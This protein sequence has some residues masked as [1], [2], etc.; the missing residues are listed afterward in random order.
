M[1]K[2]K[3]TFTV[4]EYVSQEDIDSVLNAAFEE[5]AEAQ[6]ELEL[7]DTDLVA[8]AVDDFELDDD[9][10]GLI[11][12]EDIEALLKGAANF[13]RPAPP[14][15]P[16]GAKAGK[17][18]SFEEEGSIVSQWDIDAL[19]SGE[20]TGASA[21]PA[22]AKK[23]PPEE[24]EDVAG[25]L[26]SQSDI[27]A[28]LNADMNAEAA[29]VTEAAP[30]TSTEKD[31]GGL[32]AQSEIDALLSGAGSRAMDVGKTVLSSASEEIFEPKERNEDGELIS[33]TDIDALLMEALNS[34][35]TSDAFE[36]EAQRDAVAEKTESEK[37][38]NDLAEDRLDEDVA[39]TTVILAVDEEANAP[40]VSIPFTVSLASF[41]WYLRKGYQISAMAALVLMLSFSVLF[42]RFRSPEANPQPVVLTFPMPKPD[43]KAPALVGGGATNITM[44]GFVVLASDD[45]S[46]VTYV[47]ADLLLDFS[48]ATMA[49]MIKDHEAFVRNIIYGVIHNALLSSDKGKF[50]KIKVALSVREALA[51]LV[52]GET[53]R[54]VSFEKFEM[55]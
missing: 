34:E 9:D 38:I 25:G 11:S 13:D 14:R 31:T 24:A 27:D 26:I 4:T 7:S 46:S 39:A 2:K 51:R 33:Q 21:S 12:N 1:A 49:A 19:L 43:A 50:N 20:L 22:A 54:V 45:N 30:G 16:S 8:A 47:T 40:A 17:T 37:A 53:I 44:P 36:P 28:L 15:M 35:E 23:V 29:S 3:E 18:P 55:I 48:D 52:P 41:R 10:F 5:Y 6:S 32:I 42:V